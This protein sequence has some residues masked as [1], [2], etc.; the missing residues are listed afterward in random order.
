MMKKDPK[1]YTDFSNVTNMGNELI[2]EEF[3][4]GPFGSAI[5]NADPVSNKST[6]WK[7]GQHQQGAFSYTNTEQQ[8]ESVRDYP[9]AQ[10]PL[11]EN[12][13]Q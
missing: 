5:N 6:A 7:V 4:E 3:P 1:Q 10:T 2:P 9:D 12:D 11:D 13:K 8:E